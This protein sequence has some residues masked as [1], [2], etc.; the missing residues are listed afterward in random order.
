MRT[1]RY[2]WLCLMLL[3][4]GLLLV[5][6]GDDDDKDLAPGSVQGKTYQ[7]IVT[8]GTL[9]LARSGTANVTF[10]ADGTYTVTG[11]V[12]IGNDQGTYTYNKTTD[13]SGELTLTSTQIA[14]LQITYAFVF[15][16]EKAGNFTGTLVS[17][18]AITQQ[19]TFTEL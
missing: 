2:I 8:S 11:I 17:D 10:A 3:G 12:T 1:K 9:P 19:G 13:D 6:C 14:G 5:S 7:M 4:I 16:Q 18:P 15:T